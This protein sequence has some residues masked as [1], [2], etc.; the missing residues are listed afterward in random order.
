M[1]AVGMSRW[2]FTKYSVSIFALILALFAPVACSKNHEVNLCPG[3]GTSLEY[4]GAL[5]CYYEIT[6]T[7]FSCPD[8]LPNR[9]ELPDGSRIGVA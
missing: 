4:A 5:Y 3:G 7:G 6:E 1:I 2:R 8:A 9:H